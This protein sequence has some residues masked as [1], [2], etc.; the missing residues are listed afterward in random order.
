M[1]IGARNKTDGKY[2]RVFSPALLLGLFLIAITT[3]AASIWQLRSQQAR[4]PN[5]AQRS[6][7]KRSVARKPQKLQ[8]SR[9]NDPNTAG[10]IGPSS[11]GDSVLRAPILLD[12]VKFSRGEINQS[13]TDNFSRAI[14]AYQL[15]NGLS[16]T[17]NVDPAT[18]TKL[19]QQQGTNGPTQDNSHAGS[20]QQNPTPSAVQAITTYVILL[21]DVHGPFTKLPNV[22]GP[23]AGEKLLLQEAK[24]HELNYESSLELLAE[25]F[26]SSPK[27]LVEL[28]P[29][30]AFDKAGVQINVPNVTTPDPPQ[31]AS[32]VV[33]ASTKSVTP[34]DTTG[35]MLAFY[36]ATVGSQRDPLPVG[37]WKITEVTRYPHF[38]YNPNLFWDSEN[39]HPRA[40]LPP[41][42][43]NP[44]GVV[45]IGLSKE[46][47]GIHGT[48]EPSKIAVTQSHGCIRLTNW[49]A[50]ELSKIVHVG[51]PAILKA[52]AGP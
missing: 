14:S 10:P 35:K 24:L 37:N 21:E 45:W 4:P 27:L 47:Y 20:P 9:V 39:K 46:H 1:Q 36:P 33:D 30:K 40:T 38:K 25:K 43:K 52:P 12:R 3:S 8:I 51:T 29:G 19:N 17:G 11:E 44:V 28:N 34:L 6:P 18:W 5:A 32:V 23:N 22:R 31:A 15:T 16:A 48:P 7:A 26:H 42:P 49:D 13:Y 41:G 2:C 50:L